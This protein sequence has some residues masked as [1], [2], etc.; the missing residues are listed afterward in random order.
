M[1]LALAIFDAPG[2]TPITTRTIRA[3]DTT[4]STG[5]HGYKSLETFL[6][7]PLSE[8][9][10]FFTL[11]GVAHV[12]V[13]WG[14]KRV[15]EGRLEDLSIVSGGVKLTAL[16]YWSALHDVPYTALWS[17]TQTK[18]WRAAVLTDPGQA[19]S[20]AEERYQY[21]FTNRIFISPQKGSS[22][23]A[24]DQGRAIFQLPS[25]GARGLV[26][27]Q[28]DLTHNLPVNWRIDLY[29]YTAA[30]GFLGTVV[31]INATGAIATQSVWTTF[32][33]TDILVF[34]LIWNGGGTTV[35]APE[36]G[37]GY[38]QVTNLRV[39]ASTTNAI[40]TTTTTAAVNNGA[41]V[42]IT[43]AS[44]AR[45]YAGQ[46]LILSGGGRT[47]SV[48]ISG[49]ATATQITV[50]SVVNAP[51]GGY[52]I[53][54]GVFAHVIYAD[55]IAR[56]LIAQTAAVNATQLSTSTA[57]IASPGLDLTDEAYRD[58]EPATILEHLLTRS[59]AS[60]RRW[61]AGVFDDRTLYLRV[62]GAAGT[63]YTVDATDVEIQRTLAQL[64]NSAYSIY[65]D[66]SG[67]E[68]RTAAA[69]D[70]A[71]VS[72]YGVTRRKAYTATTTN[73]TQAATLRDTVV[74]DGKQPMPRARVRFRRIADSNGVQT[75][76]ALIRSG[77]TITVRNLPPT[78]SGDI[79]RV[80]TF[81]I[82]ET[83]Y[84][85]DDTLEVTPESPLPRLDQVLRQIA[86][87]K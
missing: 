42:A 60:G 5:P 6:P 74:S 55:E 1:R 49:V 83:A 45:M 78:L 32:A 75:T 7:M 72:R 68:Q 79:D 59:D 4:L 73:A 17:S 48:V 9:F 26:G 76:K 57:L 30:G 85:D 53:G 80:R 19:G 39:V 50:L 28:F 35:Y 16:G 40:G 10:F 71:S 20:V 77:D 36:T 62:R 58:Q 24:A 87:G 8:A 11:T 82:E 67:A 65:E 84:T 47:E 69:T 44:S 13:N 51:G 56:D 31:A 63:A 21:D 52:P 66:A 3:R 18:D 33:S 29:R 25:Q 46:R 34:A 15:W 23:T 41:N 64:A 54:T 14:V 43:V 2:G 12:E 38:L 61:E 81:V 37:A 27:M 70:S 22:Y 86:K